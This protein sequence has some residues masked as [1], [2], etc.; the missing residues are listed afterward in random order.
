MCDEWRNS[1]ESFRDWARDH[2]YKDDLSIDRIDTNGN[3]EPSNCKW[4]TLKEQAYNQRRSHF[5]TYNG[6]THCIAEWADI[7]GLKADLIWS[8]MSRGHTF[9]EAISMPTKEKMTPI[10]IT[11]KGETHNVSEWSKITGI[12]YEVLI[13]RFTNLKDNY[14]VEQA[15]TEPSGHRRKHPNMI[16]Y[17]GETKD[18]KEW[19]KIVGL[20]YK[21][22]Y[23][24]LFY[25][26]WPIEKAFETPIK[27]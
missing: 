15:L 8:R 27:T 25:F 17:H 23:S 19:A 16:E 9:E 4:S 12:K 22:L 1:Y 18:L 3:Y 2:G 13:H 14:T 24:R 21:S 6:E 7:L 5:E 10:M 26:K 20:P 11:Y